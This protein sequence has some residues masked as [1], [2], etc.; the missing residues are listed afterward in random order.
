MQGNRPGNVFGRHL[1]EC[2]QLHKFD[3][4]QIRMIAG[5]PSPQLIRESSVAVAPD[6]PCARVHIFRQFSPAADQMNRRQTPEVFPA[7]QR[8]GF[9]FVAQDYQIEVC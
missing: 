6:A 2:S 8:L 7:G 1:N 4:H 3:L 9:L 5:D